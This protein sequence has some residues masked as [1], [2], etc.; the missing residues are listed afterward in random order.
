VTVQVKN[1]FIHKDKVK[2]IN[3][4]STWKHVFAPYGDLGIITGDI[5]TACYRGFISIFSLLDKQLVLDSLCLSSIDPVS[6]NGVEP[7]MKAGNAF[8]LHES[9]IFMSESFKYFY[10]NLCMKMDYS[11]SLAIETEEGSTNA[12]KFHWAR[13]VSIMGFN[14]IKQDI[15]KILIDNGLAE[16]ASKLSE[17]TTKSEFSVL[18]DE[19]EEEVYSGMTELEFKDGFLVSEKKLTIKE[20]KER[21]FYTIYHDFRRDE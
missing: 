1:F 20:F 13:E 12:Y 16:S 10:S 3:G 2:A 15:L 5:G 7:S 4:R 9:L 21:K 18:L 19:W 14:M 17:N 6:I 11:G 8:N